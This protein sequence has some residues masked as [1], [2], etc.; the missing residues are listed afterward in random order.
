MERELFLPMKELSFTRE[1][2][3]AEISVFKKILPYIESFQSYGLTHEIF[4]SKKH[5]KL[6]SSKGKLHLY[7]SGLEHS[8]RYFAICKN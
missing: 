1:Q 8:K 6:R 2:V 5:R 4:D 3:N 7:N